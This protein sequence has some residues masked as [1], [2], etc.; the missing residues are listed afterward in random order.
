MAEESE[1]SVIVYLRPQTKEA[2]A[3]LD[4]KSNEVFTLVVAPPPEPSDIPLNA[5]T[6]P[7]RGPIFHSTSIMSSITQAIHVRAPQTHLFTRGYAGFDSIPRST[8]PLEGLYS[9]PDRIL[10]S[11][12]AS[13]AMNQTISEST[14][15]WTVALC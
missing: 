2:I 4:R 5:V 3:I 14:T 15:I 11:K 9:D 13:R 8:T 6:G 12:W 7:A 10:I 1:L